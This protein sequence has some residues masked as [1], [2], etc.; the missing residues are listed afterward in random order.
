MMTQKS[1]I[2]TNKLACISHEMHLTQTAKIL[3]SA[4]DLTLA[5]EE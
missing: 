5:E 3:N 1:E 2:A 4:V